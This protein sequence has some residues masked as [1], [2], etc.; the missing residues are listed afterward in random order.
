MNLEK[1]WSIIEQIKAS[2]K[3]EEEI[4]EILKELQPDE[5]ASYQVHFDTLHK[6][7]YTWALWGAAYI[8]E[9]GCSDDGFIDFRYGLI[10][11]GKSVYETAL[12]D[13]DSLSAL[14]NAWLS[15]ELFGYSALDIYEE[16]TSKDMPRKDFEAPDSPVGEEWDFNDESENR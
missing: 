3:P 7:A 2:D 13:P 16:K 11:K 4:K 8:I 15:N 12:K 6:T 9:G 1:F 14:P 5:I 10:A